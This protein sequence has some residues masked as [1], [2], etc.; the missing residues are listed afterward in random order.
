MFMEKHEDYNFTP[1]SCNCIGNPRTIHYPTALWIHCI[2]LCAE[3]SRNPVSNADIPSSVCLLVTEALP[4][5]FIHFCCGIF[6]HC[7]FI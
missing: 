7:H 1:L 3:C 4:L 2:I 5:D 6:L